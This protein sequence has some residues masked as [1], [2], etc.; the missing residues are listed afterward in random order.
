MHFAFPCVLLL[1]R[2]PALS[3][4]CEQRFS[5]DASELQMPM[6]CTGGFG[7]QGKLSQYFMPR[8]TS[9]TPISISRVTPPRERYY[10]DIPRSSIPILHVAL[11]NIQ[12]QTLVGCKTARRASECSAISL[13]GAMKF[14]QVLLAGLHVLTNGQLSYTTH[15][16]VS[17]GDCDRFGMSCATIGLWDCKAQIAEAAELIRQSRSRL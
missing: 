12:Q 11:P 6:K 13:Q 8:G 7:K 3:D 2:R 15:S 4:P 1:A 16:H 9:N 17:Q 5:S 14:L 10:D